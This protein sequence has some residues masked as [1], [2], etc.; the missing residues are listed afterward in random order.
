MHR[1]WCFTAGKAKENPCVIGKVRKV[2]PKIPLRVDANGGWTTKQAIAMSKFLFENDV[3]FIEQPLPKYAHVDNWRLVR[4]HSP[5]PIFADESIMRSADVA[6]LAGTI[7]GVVV[8]LAK[9]GGLSEALKVIHTARAHGLQVMFGCMIESSLGVTAAAQLQSLCD[10]LDLDG[11]L[12]L[13][14][15]PFIGVQY[16]DGYLRLP[17]APGLG[18]RPA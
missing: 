10:H 13:A 8:K 12:L 17:D 1:G 15:D 6:R 7:D 18:V 5:L 9:A 11:S 14:N 16:H 4:E 2:A 3:Q